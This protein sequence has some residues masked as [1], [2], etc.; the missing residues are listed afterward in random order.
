MGDLSY[1]PLALASKSLSTQEIVLTHSDTVE[2]VRELAKLGV[3]VVDWEAWG[4]FPDGKKGHAG[5][6]RSDYPGRHSSET[7]T[8]FVQRA[9]RDCL[10]TVSNAD[11]HL[12][13]DPNFDGVEIHFCLSITTE[14]ELE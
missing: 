3:A 9:A 8:E 6:R 10:E 14:R 5:V 2:A 7:W 12:R 4:L 11:A 1:L 13:A